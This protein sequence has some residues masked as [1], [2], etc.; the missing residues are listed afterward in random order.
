MKRPEIETLLPGV[1]QRTLRP[2]TPLT[3][4]LEVMEALHAP[5][6]AIL[7]RLDAIFDARRAPDEFI[8]FLARWVNLERILFE[9]PAG[10]SACPSLTTGLGRLRELIAAAS[11]LSQWRGTERGLLFF[12]EIATGAGNYRIDRQ[13]LREDGQTRPFHIRITAPP[14]MVEHR[15]L[16]ERIVEQ[17]KP[18]YVT[19][20]IVFEQLEEAAR[21]PR[22][23]TGSSEVFR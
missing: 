22:R 8:P 21:S 4:L 20:E 12:L 5:S 13:V 1:F 9:P 17:E 23:Q 14:G 18:A 7:E 3:A 6:E 11:Y 16:I 15:P 2:G 10:K 19:V